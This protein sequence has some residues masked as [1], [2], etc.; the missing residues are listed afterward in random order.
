MA[1]IGS[2]GRVRRTT[3]L[4]LAILTTLTLAAPA[5]ATAGGNSEA[6]AACEDG[7]YLDWTDEDRNPFRNTGACVSYAAHGGTLVPVV[8]DPVNPF[9]VTYQ[10]FGADGFLA[11]VTGS[12]LQPDSSV[13]F[14]LTWGGAPLTI[15]NLADGSGNATFTASGSCTSMGSPLTAVSVAGTPA[16][17]EQTEF[18]LPLPGTSVCPSPT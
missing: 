2:G 10:P 15:G 4:A 18:P 1:T 6:A 16:G 14:M 12:G 3:T 13:D 17:G 9:S 5:L 8:V 11:T 7:G